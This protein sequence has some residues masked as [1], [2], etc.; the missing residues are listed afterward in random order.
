MRAIARRLVRLEQR[1]GLVEET[2]EAKIL[3]AR[4]EA[5]RLRLETAGMRSATPPPSPQRLAD[6]KGM[7]V[8]GILNA[9]R[10]RLALARSCELQGQTAREYKLRRAASQAVFPTCPAGR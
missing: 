5:A 2:R 7:G 8:V 3:W 9:A 1:F 6:L 4:L 10:D